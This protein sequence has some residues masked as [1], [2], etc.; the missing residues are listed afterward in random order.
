M[1][2]LRRIVLAATAALALV[3]GLAGPAG[4]APPASDFRYMGNGIWCPLPWLETSF[5]PLSWC[6]E[7]AGNYGGAGW[8]GPYSEGV[9]SWA[10][11]RP[12]TSRSACVIKKVQESGGGNVGL[13]KTVGG[14]DSG[15]F[16]EIRT[17]VLYANFG[18]Q[19]IGRPGHVAGAGPLDTD[20]FFSTGEWLHATGDYGP[21]R[22][23]TWSCSATS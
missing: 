10:N 13:A 20:Q 22:N 15:G 16:G 11:D 6:T 2:I 12:I 4:A 21:Q 5:G 17:G 8:Y 19:P 18:F 3:A 1:V 9:P 23:Y 14:L 7:I